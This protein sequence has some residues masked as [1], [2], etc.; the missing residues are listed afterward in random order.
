MSQVGSLKIKG[1]NLIGVFRTLAASMAIELR[2]VKQRRGDDSP[3]YEVFTEDGN[4][5]AVSVG[6]AWI[7]KGTADAMKGKMFLSITIDDPSMAAP[8]N[9]TAFPADGRAGEYEI[10]W[11]RARQQGRAA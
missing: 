5:D 8:L 6:A 10:V 9:L 1:E 3:N 2:P 7:K 11:R 4:G